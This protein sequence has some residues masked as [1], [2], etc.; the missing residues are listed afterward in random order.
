M[1]IYAVP[2]F[3]NA[4]VAIIVL[5]I[6]TRYMSPGE[7]GVL[8]NFNVLLS[9]LTIL[10][11]FS[12]QGAITVNYYKLAK[13]DLAH[14]VANVFILLVISA[15]LIFCILLISYDYFAEKIG[16]SI[17]WVLLAVM[18]AAC[19]LVTLINLALLQAEQKSGFFSALQIT[20]SVLNIVLSLLLVVTFTLGW[21]GRVMG[22]G[23][24]II[25]FSIIS[26]LILYR[27]GYLSFRLNQKYFKDAL[28]FG[29]PLIPH[30]LSFWLRSGIDRVIL[31]LMISTVATGIYNVSFQVGSILLMVFTAFNQA[32]VP[33]LYKTLQNADDGQK[34]KMVK[35]TYLYF[36]AALMIAYVAMLVFPH[37]INLLVDEKYQ[38]ASSYIGFICFGF[39]FQAMYFMVVSYVFYVK[40]TKALSLITFSTGVSHIFICYWLVDRHGAIGAAQA[41]TIS[42][43]LTFLGV[44]LLSAKVY[45]MPWLL[46]T[47]V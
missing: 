34:T 41:F 18:F 32:W 40:E 17:G 44:W 6:M 47:R 5:P 4:A 7:Y 20:S 19:N 9:V 29:L 23:I 30:Q 16:L 2:S 1:A 12:S 33:Y 42:S 36:V 31:T 38:G 27:K 15:L 3:F 45:K 46:S 10:V 35:F 22:S 13:K 26:G 43:C 14:Y 21:P 24:S 11:G 28:A 37:I 39:A 8:A 25:I